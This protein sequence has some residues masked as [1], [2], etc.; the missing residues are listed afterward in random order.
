MS[1]ALERSDGLSVVSVFSTQTPTIDIAL[2]LVDCCQLQ[3]LPSLRSQT[4]YHRAFRG[5]NPGQEVRVLVSHDGRT[6]EL[7]CDLTQV[8]RAL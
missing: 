6:T 3:V 1:V 7:L 5:R 2:N 4:G 8:I